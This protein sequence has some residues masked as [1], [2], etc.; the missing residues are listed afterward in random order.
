MEVVENQL[1]RKSVG[2][3]FITIKTCISLIDNYL[4][5]TCYHDK[6]R[7]SFNVYNNLL[8]NRDR[9]K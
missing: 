2:D 4:R 1:Y 8:R 5:F 7:K 6:I 9:V 3:V